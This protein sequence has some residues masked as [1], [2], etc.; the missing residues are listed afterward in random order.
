MSNA[1]RY[2][3]S[4]FQQKFSTA[5]GHDFLRLMKRYVVDY[6]NSH[7][8]EQTKTV[9]TPNYALRMGSHFV[10]GRDTQYHAATRKQMDQ[11][12]GLG[13]TV[14]EIWTSGE[15]L[16]MRFSEHGASIKHGGKLASW[17]GIGLYKW[18]GEALTFNSVE[19]DYYSRARQLRFGQPIPVEPP[20][21]APW[22]TIPQGPNPDNEQV[23]RQWLESGL[24][25]TTNNVLCDDAWAGSPAEQIISQ[26]SIVI[27]DLFSSGPN[28]AFHISQ[29]GK[30]LADFAE[31]PTSVGRAVTLHMAGIVKVNS[32]K[33]VQGR[34]VRNRLELSRALSK[35]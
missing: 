12:P 23:V 14:H 31:D 2:S 8:Q 26:E 6:T 16:M 28:V 20:A 29:Y 4:S 1:K 3:M 13:I 27:N 15:R 17:S 25:S 5:H 33:V 9:M 30:L 19:Q 21:I 24:V 22:D 32:R 18:N 35:S 7:D 10:E 11:F 34:I